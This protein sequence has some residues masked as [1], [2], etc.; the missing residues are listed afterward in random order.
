MFGAGAQVSHD[1]LRPA[2]DPGVEALQDEVR[3]RGAF[4]GY[5]EGV[6]DV[7]V[8]VFLYAQYSFASDEILRDVA[9]AIHAFSFIREYSKLV[10]K[11][12]SPLGDLWCWIPITT[13]LKAIIASFTYPVSKSAVL[14]AN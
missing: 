8:A 5:Q 3:G 7:A 2:E 9:N 13:I 14:K 4:Y 10:S 6:M 1:Q 11:S 12:T